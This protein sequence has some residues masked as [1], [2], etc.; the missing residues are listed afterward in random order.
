MAVLS[1]YGHGISIERISFDIGREALTIEYDVIPEEEGSQFLQTHALHGLDELHILKEQRRLQ[2]SLE[3]VLPCPDGWDIRVATRASSQAVAQLPWT[4]RATRIQTSP[5]SGGETVTP[6]ICF[7]IRHSPLLDDHSILKVKILIE[8]SSS[9]KGIRL[10]G[11]PHDVEDHDARDPISFSMSNE[12]IQD[13]SSAINASI[14][15]GASIATVE[16]DGSSMSSPR[17]PALLRQNSNMS[18]PP[19]ADKSIQTLVRR[20]YIYFSSLLQEPEAKWRRSEFIL[21]LLSLSQWW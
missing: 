7:Q 16:S 2:R 19:A 12:L 9:L 5:F 10:D 6:R 21:F 17:K 18:R 8:Y 1:G 13:A 3:C 15:T 4:S 20:N 14:H 11:L